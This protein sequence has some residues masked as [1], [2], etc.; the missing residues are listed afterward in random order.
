MRRC[1]LAALVLASGAAAAQ[2]RVNKLGAML[3]EGFADQGFWR[4]STGP[5]KVAPVKDGGTVSAKQQFQAR[6]SRVD[7]EATKCDALFP[8]G[9]QQLTL[10]V[11]GIGGAGEEWEPA[12][13]NLAANGTPLLMYRW[14]PTGSREGIARSLADGINR[15]QECLAG[16]SKRLLVLGHSAGGVLG[17]TA[18]SWVKP[19]DDSIADRIAIVTVA[20]PLGGMGMKEKAKRGWTTFVEELGADLRDYQAAA[21]GVRVLHVRTHPRADSYSVNSSPVG[22]D[23]GWPVPG[24]PGARAVD[25]DESVN[26]EQAIAFTAAALKQDVWK[27]WAPAGA[28]PVPPPPA[29]PAPRPEQ[30]PPRPIPTA[31]PGQPV[32]L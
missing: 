10:T 24:V 11:H 22:H 14:L 18:A 13:G 8:R 29:E 31:P 16:N 27:L 30:R 12:L 25:L 4:L 2:S 7:L 5:V 23:E 19:D 6:L 20:A 32:R 3:A 26:H 21:P 9:A 28:T 17:A 15:L 1:L